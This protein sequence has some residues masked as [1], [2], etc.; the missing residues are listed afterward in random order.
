LSAVALLARDLDLLL[1]V[2]D[3]LRERPALLVLLDPVAERFLPLVALAGLALRALRLVERPALAER[4]LLGR[5]LD[6]GRALERDLDLLDE[7]FLAVRDLP[8]AFLTA[9]RLGLR[10]NTATYT[11]VR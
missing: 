10:T 7:A 5:F 9:A 1:A 2:A 3:E 4:A 11:C 8:L 6:A